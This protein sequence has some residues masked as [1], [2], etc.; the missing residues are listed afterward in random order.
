MS[1]RQ[2]QPSTG[3]N[4]ALKVLLWNLLNGFE[5]HPYIF[6]LRQSPAG[7]DAAYPFAHQVELLYKL[8]VRK[9][10]RVLI[11][12]EIGLGKTIEAIMLLKY[13]QEVGEVK[14]ALILVP[15]ILINQW[16][17]ELRRFGTEP[18]KIERNT[19][20]ELV[21]RGLPDGAYLSSIDLVKRERYEQKVLNSKWDIVIADEAH[22]IGIVGGKK[23]NRYL[24][25]EK[26]ISKNPVMNIVLL[27]ATPHRGKID[28]YIQRLKLVDSNLYADVDKLNSEE[29][30]YKYVNNALVFRR[31]KLDV[32]EVYEKAPVFKPCEFTAYVVEANDSEKR[33]YE[34]L[35]TFLQDKLLEYYGK[36]GKE[37]RELALLLTLIAKRASSSPAAALKT[38][39]KMLTKRSA[40]LMGKPEES[41]KEV[42]KKASD[43][44]DSLFTTFEEYGEIFDETG[45]GAVK[46]IDDVVEEFTKYLEPLL[47]EGDHESLEELRSLA[48]EITSKSK[49]SRL[50]E[51]IKLVSEHLQ[52]SDRVVI[53][54]EFKD[55]AEYVYNALLKALPQP[56]R[57]KV[58]LVTASKIEPPKALNKAPEARE[59]GI[60]DVKNW[61]KKGLVDVIVSTDVASEGLNLQYANVI[62]HYEPTWSPIKIVQRIGRVW[63]V[64]QEKNVYSY[65]VLLTTKS[66]L[67]VFENLY[68]KLLSWLIAGVESKVVIGEK[69]RISFLKEKG[70]QY[71]RV[72]VFTMPVTGSG[73]EKG[74]SEYRAIME[75]LKEGEGGLELYVNQI[76]SLLK[77]LKQVSEKV[78]GERG[79]K[80]VTVENIIS[81]GL[82]GLCRKEAGEALL[83]I[84]ENLAQSRGCQ[85]KKRED[86]VRFVNC[87]ELGVVTSIESTADAYRVITELTRTTNINEPV[88]LLVSSINNKDLR[89]LHLF[90][91]TAKLGN[92]VIYSE[93]VGIGITETREIIRGA[94]LLSL[95]AEII[96][97]VI[98]VADSTAFSNSNIA[99]TARSIISKALRNY[100]I[101]PLENYVQFVED[102]NLSQ[103]HENWESVTKP[104][105]VDSRWI[106]S[107]LFVS[108]DD[109]GKEASPP[110]IKVEEVE[111]KAME[112]VM[113]FEERSG[114][115]PEDVSKYEHYD[116]M[117][118]DPR[119][120]EVR[121]IEVKGR[122][123]PTLVVELTETE[124]EYAKKFGKDYWL[125]IVYD[126]GSGKPRLVIIRDPINNVIWQQVPTY[127]Y[128]LVGMRRGTGETT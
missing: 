69:L 5:Y 8:F 20:D 89:E 63:R 82:G 87:P 11:G 83:K 7:K 121:Y 123:G 120:G 17:S 37:P 96:P 104:I 107:I 102:R 38:F 10:L 13:L 124:F 43:I 30:F 97:N 61:L 117:S 15:R 45:K 72:D 53:F 127:R 91:V 111:K 122:W 98:G 81:D 62:I 52:K 29:E 76:L 94:Q 100:V 46:D 31:T 12:D 54:T 64:G 50:I 6:M 66:D 59:Y 79:D 116:I 56:H 85:I 119:T 92:R 22:R 65:N 18:Q 4:T 90:E 44:I 67:A 23:N 32:N 110:P 60:E 34:S 77:E 71:D 49:D 126:I 51:V 21:R 105:S 24:F 19:I 39:S 108:S 68:G 40:T 42:E 125:Y 26:L 112:F 27:S 115:E 55:T 35:V 74:Y 14:K 25:L 99:F 80:R 95:V 128:R 109:T 28:D 73:E 93:V 41:L 1:Q 57:D 86:E 9:P 88:V 36:A 118:R 47:G 114:R 16:E 48:Q 113:D 75:F 70:T 106:G 101:F 3:S 58:C 103:K 2:S 84:L 33:F 78:E